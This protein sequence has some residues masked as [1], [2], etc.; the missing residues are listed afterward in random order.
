MRILYILFLMCILGQSGW[1]QND[2]LYTMYV[3]NKL[4][5]NSAYAGSKEVLNIGAHYRHQWEGI[6][7]APR[8]ITAFGHTPLGQGRSGIGL[9][10]ISDDIGLVNSTTFRA[11][12]AYRIGF[13]NNSTLSMGLGAQV[14]LNRFDWTLADI[15]NIVDDLIPFGEPSNS[16]FDFG[17]GVY[18]SGPKFYVGYSMPRML[19][20]SLS[21]HNMTDFRNINAMR[22][23]YLMGGVVF[24]LGSKVHLKPSF[25]VSYIDNVPIEFDLNVSLLFLES[26]WVG[27]SYRL[28]D[29][30]DAFVQFPLSRQLKVALGADFTLSELNTLTKGSLELMVEY[31]F[32]YDNEK[33]NNIRFF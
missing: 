1:S 25:L 9:S 18:Y 26:F 22:I 24:P 10:V 21:N 5:Y 15:D 12:Y 20:N 29:S 3:F 7:G 16:T 2:R 14:E 4:Q 17:L 11:D 31:M 23:H 30:A 27:A 13:K 8:T 28:G 32:V 6:E 33:I 19:A